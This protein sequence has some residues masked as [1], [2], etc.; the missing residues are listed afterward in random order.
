MAPGWHRKVYDQ[1]AR[2]RAAEY[3]TPRY[4]ATRQ[5]VKAQ[6]DAGLA[7]CWRCTEPIPPGSAWHLG[8]DD[9]DRSIIRGAEHPDCNLKAA[10]SKGA[11][12]A[13]ARRRPKPWTSRPW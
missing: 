5:A 12:V 10:A 8:H 2:A 3:R 9:L 7:R 13:N 4:K 6:V 11:R 1:A